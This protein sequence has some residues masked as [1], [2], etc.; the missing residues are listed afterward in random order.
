MKEIR[1]VMLILGAVFMTM[2]LI[3]VSVGA[4]QWSVCSRLEREGVSVE[5]TV[6][7]ESSDELR[8]LF[9]AEGQAWNVESMFQSDGIRTGETLKVWYLPGNPAG[10]R[11]IDWW[12]YG[13]FLI[14][15][16]VIGATGWGFIGWHMIA[17]R[18]MRHLKANGQKVLADVITVKQLYSVRING[19]HPYVIYASCTHPYS[20]SAMTVKSR[21]LMTDPTPRLA[22]GKVEVLVDMMNEKRYYM[23]AE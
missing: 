6:R 8:L 12:T 22:D 9:E 19:R 15:G 5:A 7:W 2:G 16:G 1:K 11:I 20:G 23:L 4:W 18:R 10:A 17:I 13:I 3:F 21:M 14:V